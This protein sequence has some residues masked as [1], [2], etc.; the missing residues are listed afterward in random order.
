MMGPFRVVGDCVSEEECMAVAFVEAETIRHGD[1]GVWFMP[2][3]EPSEQY[4]SKWLLMDGA[5]EWWLACKYFAVRYRQDF[6]IPV[7]RVSVIISGEPGSL[8][9]ELSARL[10][11]EVRALRANPPQRSDLVVF[12]EDILDQSRIVA[13][14]DLHRRQWVS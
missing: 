12:A 8:E 7:A 10:A 2:S 3:L 4:A 9:P 13:A 11:S 6:H 14:I 1:L 5:G